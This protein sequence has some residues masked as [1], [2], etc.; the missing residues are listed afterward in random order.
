VFV[1]PCA[2]EVAAAI[3]GLAGLLRRADGSGNSKAESDRGKL[4]HGWSNA[5]MLRIMPRLSFFLAGA[6]G[7]FRF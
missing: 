5:M 2:G 6:Q 7:A 4:H 1:P 3:G